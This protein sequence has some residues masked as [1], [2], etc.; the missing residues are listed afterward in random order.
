MV[1]YDRLVD[2]F[3]L[4]YVGEKQIDGRQ[5]PTGI[6]AV[7][8]SLLPSV[9]PKTKRSRSTTNSFCGWIEE[10]AFPA[11]VDAE[12]IGEHSRL[13]QGTTIH[14]ADQRLPDGVW[15]PKMNTVRFSVKFLKVHTVR[16][17]AVR[18]SSEFHK[19]QTDSTLQFADK[20]K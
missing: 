2:V 3:D 17:E 12:I 1:P 14:A 8:K 11:Q 13:Q 19:F 9:H 5:A 10:D 4:R 7:P 15:M 16:G 6:E 18:T 20:E